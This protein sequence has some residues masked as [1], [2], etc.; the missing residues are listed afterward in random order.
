M[1]SWKDIW[2]CC[3]VDFRWLPGGDILISSRTNVGIYYEALDKPGYH[4]GVERVARDWDGV[5][6]CNTAGKP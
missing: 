3:V 2:P 1:F 6:Y 5:F 4:A